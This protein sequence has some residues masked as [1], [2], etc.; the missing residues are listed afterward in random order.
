MFFKLL[1]Y[2]LSGDPHQS[3]IAAS[4]SR[5]RRAATKVSARSGSAKIHVECAAAEKIRI[6]GRILAAVFYSLQRLSGNAGPTLVNLLIL[7]R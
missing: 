5:W 6:V 4:A 3:A 1:K 2:S 7:D